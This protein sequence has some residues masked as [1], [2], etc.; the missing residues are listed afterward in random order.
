MKLGANW[1]SIGKYFHQMDAVSVFC[2]WP[3]L[4]GSFWSHWKNR[5]SAAEQNK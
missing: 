1:R 3:G 5:M 4:H 2:W